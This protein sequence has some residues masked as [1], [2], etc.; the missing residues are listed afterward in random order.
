V[1]NVSEVAREAGANRKT[2]EGFLEV[3]LYRGDR[4]L[5]QGNVLCL[6]VE[7][8]LTELRPGDTLPT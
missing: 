3:L 4:R 1:L 5:R 7:R 6:P 2:V 8:S